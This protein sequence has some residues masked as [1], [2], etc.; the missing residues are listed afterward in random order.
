MKEKNKDNDWF[1]K[2]D[3]PL[4]TLH[5]QYA[6]LFYKKTEISKNQIILNE[7]NIQNPQTLKNKIRKFKK[8]FDEKYLLKRVNINNYKNL[9]KD[10]II[11]KNILSKIAETNIKKSSRNIRSNLKRVKTN[12]DYNKIVSEK[13]NCN[14]SIIQKSY[15]LKLQK[16][17]LDNSL[18]NYSPITE[19]KNEKKLY[20][21]KNKKFILNIENSNLNRHNL[22]SSKKGLKTN[23][24]IENKNEEENNNLFQTLTR[25]EKNKINN[26]N[27]NKPKKI[28][29]F[30]NMMKAIKDGE[31]NFKLLNKNI[32][33]LKKIK[34]FSNSVQNKKI[35][36]SIKYSKIKNRKDIELKILN[37]P[38]VNI[39][40]YFRKNIKFNSQKDLKNNNENN[41]NLYDANNSIIDRKKGF[42]LPIV[43]SSQKE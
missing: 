40:E 43:P 8:Y 1:K 5:L 38:Q 4:K 6:K 25:I 11:I 13:I 2:L 30:F 18:L 23:L 34:K 27:R 35:N 14:K 15:K 7:Y 37:S 24:T 33:E 20:K 3:G 41:K 32:I 39:Y 22:S 21:I 26:S 28:E 9:D 17:N 36:T 19:R 16:T 29:N 10:N 31:K 42:V 12:N